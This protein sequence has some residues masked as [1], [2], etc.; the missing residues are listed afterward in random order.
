M[1]FSR[2]SNTAVLKQVG[3]NGGGEDN[4]TYSDVKY[5]DIYKVRKFSQGG[6]KVWADSANPEEKYYGRAR[7]NTSRR[8]GRSKHDS[9][10]A[11]RYG[12]SDNSNASAYSAA[13]R[14]RSD[15]RKSSTRYGSARRSSS[16]RNTCIVIN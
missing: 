1:N 15:A 7:Q 8:Y 14:G 4:N 12:R 16:R 2:F 6:E 13:R 10:A 3:T 11:A 5:N 9:N